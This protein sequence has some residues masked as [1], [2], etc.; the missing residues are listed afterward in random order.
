MDRRLFLIRSGGAAATLASGASATGVRALQTYRV[1]GSRVN[2]HLE[3]LSRFGRN[4]QGGVSRVS[5]SEADVVGWRFAM[6]LMRDAGLSV[7]ID[8]FGNLLVRRGGSAPGAL[9]VAF[10]SRID[11]VPEGGNYDG[12]VGAM[13]A[14]EVAHT[15]V[16]KTYRA[17]AIRCSLPSAATRKAASLA[18]VASSAG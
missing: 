1:N 3:G 9:P 8:A 16:G 11:S 17:T 12:D 13:G 14:I 15:L 18:V 4:S 7:E 6:E 10:G 2:A 5:F